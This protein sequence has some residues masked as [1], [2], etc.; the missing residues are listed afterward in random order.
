MR[1]VEDTGTVLTVGAEKATI[2]LDHKRKDC[3]GCCACS[4]FGTA[5]YTIEVARG[6]L[7][8][9]ERV[10]VRIPRVNEYVSMLL[11]FILPLVLFM[12][13]IAAGRLFEPDER[14]GGAS[15]SGGVVGLVVAFAIA[16]TVNRLVIR[17]AV[18]EA[19]RLQ[20]EQ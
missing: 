9:G 1:Y 17:K 2:R 18:P 6:E 14:I 5:A 10:R 11:V 4:A 19:H 15:V 16:W 8:E 3:A 12:G 7:Q 20:P 13:G